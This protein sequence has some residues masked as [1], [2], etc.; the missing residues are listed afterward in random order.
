VYR[1]LAEAR[2]AGPPTSKAPESLEL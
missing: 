2:A 1:I